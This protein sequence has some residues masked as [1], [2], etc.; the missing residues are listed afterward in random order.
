MVREGIDSI[1]LN[2][3]TVVSTRQRIAYAEKTLGKKGKKTSPKFLSLVVALGIVA[4][5]IITLGA[6]CT[7]QSIKENTPN[8]NNNE[9][10]PAQIREKIT[11]VK[12]KEFESQM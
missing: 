1:S 10:S 6:G 8:I 4:G 9:L 11:Q 5:G 7:N 2:P 3:D 12:N